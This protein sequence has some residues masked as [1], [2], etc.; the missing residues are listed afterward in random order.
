MTLRFVRISMSYNVKENILAGS[1]LPNI[2]LVDVELSSGFDS[3]S[4][5]TRDPHIQKTNQQ[6]ARG[7]KR[8]GEDSTSGALKVKLGLHIK[9][10]SV[11]KI[12]SNRGTS[13][14]MK[15]MIVQCTNEPAHERLTNSFSDFVA[16]YIN[17]GE[18]KRPE[19]PNIKVRSM[20]LTKFFSENARS[21]FS[22][23]KSEASLTNIPLDQEFIIETSNETDQLSFL[24]Y[25]ITCYFDNQEYQKYISAFS[26]PTNEFFNSRFSEVTSFGNVTSEVV[27]ANGTT[28]K[29]SYAFHDER[30][31]CFW[32]GPTHQMED[33][34]YMKGSTHGSP[35]VKSSA[36]NL[37]T[38]DN[39]KIKDHRVYD[40][41]QK[42]DFSALDPTNKKTSDK[43]L[44]DRARIDRNVSLYN[45]NP[46]FMSDLMISRDA[47]NS[48]RFLF[49]INIEDIIKQYS[50]FPKVLENVKSTNSQDHEFILRNFNIS[51][52]VLKRTQ[53]R[54]E[55]DL[56]TTNDPRYNSFQDNN[57]F[58]VV[59]SQDNEDRRGL[60]RT[61][62]YGTGNEDPFFDREDV[63]P[64]LYGSV[65]QV[66]LF[67]SNKGNM[68]R[69]YTGTDLDIAS[70]TSGKY[71]YSL[72]LEFE[73]SIER[74][75]SNKLS[76]LRLLIYGEGRTLGL[77]QYYRDSISGNNKYYNDQIGQFRSSFVEY[78][79]EKYTTNNN[80]KSGLLFS[81]SKAYIDIIFALK[82]SL[83]Q[84]KLKQNDILSYILNIS[85]P[86][87]GSPE[88][89]LKL[90][91]L[92]KNLETTLQK[93]INKNSTY[94]RFRGDV[95]DS[96]LASSAGV[97]KNKQSKKIRIDHTFTQ[98]YDASA[99][100]KIGFDYLNS[101]SKTEARN[102]NGLSVYYGK[103][104]LER[105][106]EETSKYFNSTSPD[107]SMRDKDQRLYNPGDDVKNT[108]FSFLTIS[109]ARL[110]QG[111]SNIIFSNTGV[112]TNSVNIEKM[113]DV[114]SAVITENVTKGQILNLSSESS[115]DNFAN[116][117]LLEQAL[118]R[119][120]DI[121]N[122]RSIRRGNEKEKENRHFNKESK[123]DLINSGENLF[124]EDDNT[125]LK[126]TLNNSKKVLMANQLVQ[127]KDFTSHK[128]SIKYYFLNDEEGA[129]EIKD[130]LSSNR[131][132]NVLINAPN[133][134]KSLMLSLMKSGNVNRFGAFDEIG[135]DLK[136]SVDI[137]KDPKYAGFVFF[138]YKNIRKIEVFSGYETSASGILVNSPVFRPMTERDLN[139]SSNV[140]L[141]CRHIKYVDDIYGMAK[142]EQT[143]LPSYDEYF[144]IYSKGNRIG[145]KDY[146][147]FSDDYRTRY[148]SKEAKRANTEYASFLNRRVS[149]T[150]VS[151]DNRDI[152]VRPEYLNSNIVNKNKSIYTNGMI[153]LQNSKNTMDKIKSLDMNSVPNITDSNS[154]FSLISAMG[155]VSGQNIVFN[156]S[157]QLGNAS[158]I[159]PPMTMGGGSS[160]T[161]GGG[162][163]GSSTY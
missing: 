81:V 87:S 56:R 53:L 108:K 76:N 111:K 34:T 107:L 15:M 153:N 74:L 147:V 21:T 129:Q 52:F 28:N 54:S 25:F 27:I 127:N 50:Q 135:T 73:D 3:H 123:A 22:Y 9:S 14:F 31:D 113:N 97:Q 46:N 38:T 117:L 140:P 91:Q 88:G 105:F 99:N 58:V 63:K 163:G 161:T 106:D 11:S 36:L 75:L 4:K 120:V 70:K 6:K 104:M 132:E 55:G 13:S 66:S 133:Q 17:S 93:I 29:V 100:S 94:R 68:I 48:A 137:F 23:G 26:K 86:N 60:L 136:S 150:E 141:L 110:T 148:V 5:K 130:R 112:K 143:M 102:A 82:G 138:N 37:I 57:A 80:P 126:E 142:S 152:L 144:L 43:Q 7:S 109:N 96:T 92:S 69:T 19:N 160:M 42:L 134:I 18:R 35:Y 119:Q 41:L 64:K 49:S 98:E 71:K 67:S 10:S 156:N 51:D 157:T 154:V 47:S 16:S 131:K 44:I 125:R 149:T 139:L 146:F 151:T 158:S 114:L 72:E 122:S 8:L 65:E 30:G 85:S 61:A 83:G 59:K 128:N 101:F 79:N 2:H 62:K 1:I 145:K 155:T 78:Y 121:Y 103:T 162:G 32:I 89:I 118:S 90:I 124:I 115:V 33:G 24:S 20:S 116:S 40:A 39:I 77:E 12:F 84:L 95:S 159:S 45:S